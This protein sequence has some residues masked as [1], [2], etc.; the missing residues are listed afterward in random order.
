MPTMTPMKK[1]SFERVCEIVYETS[2]IA[3]T[4]KKEALVSARVSKRMRAL[5]ISDFEKYL[6]YLEDHHDQEIVGLLDAVSTNVTSFFRE[7]HHFDFI[8]DEVARW[9][10]GGQR[11][12][13]FWSAAC[14]TGEEPL[15]LAMVLK[16]ALP[17]PDVDARVLATDISTVTLS[18]CGQA[19]YEDRKVEPIPY[20]LRSRWFT[21]A[22]GGSDRVWTAKPALKQMIVYRRLNLSAP[23]FP[24]RGPLD[25]VFCRNVM[26]YFDDAVRIQLL[27][28]IARL[29]K[30]GGY[31]F[32][33]HAESLAGILSGF[34]YV[35]PSI[36]RKA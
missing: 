10:E 15:S 35:R 32:V 6:I 13:R 12:F 7:P 17:Y 28:E 4:A 36:Y 21:S 2:G 5:G 1:D 9:Y 26:I 29:L 23:P 25:A 8:G 20:D 11:R 3:L 34:K 14:S 31:L 24:M 22:G 18:H 27:D 33:G 30:P 19:A 16:E